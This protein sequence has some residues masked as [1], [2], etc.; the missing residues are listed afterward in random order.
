M[1]VSKKEPEVSNCK[2]TV[3]KLITSK[4]QILAKY[5][6]VFD[7]VGQFSGP[8]YNSQVDHSVTPK[9]TPVDQSL[10]IRKK[11]SRRRL[12]RCYKQEF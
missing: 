12:T 4:E 10:F 6:D 3:P 5:A 9:Q 7:G 2:G 11:L 1:H 8:P